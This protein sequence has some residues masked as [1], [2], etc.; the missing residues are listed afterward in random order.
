MDT[1]YIIGKARLE[2]EAKKLYEKSKE[3][4][5]GGVKRGV[6]LLLRELLSKYMDL[7]ILEQGLREEY[8]E[9]CCYRREERELERANGMENVFG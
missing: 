2:G 8:G 7:V 6:E 5:N 4:H 9:L 3:V 1:F